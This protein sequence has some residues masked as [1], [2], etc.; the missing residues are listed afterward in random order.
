MTAK[1]LSPTTRRV[2][3]LTVEGFTAKQVAAMT[4]R[5]TGTVAHHLR[6]V[7]AAWGLDR[8]RNLRVQL[9]R[10]ITIDSMTKLLIAQAEAMH[11]TAL[12]NAIQQA[13]QAVAAEH[14]HD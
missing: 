2:V 14:E 5:S 10:R 9:A 7:S 13:T 3:E 1:P 6:L 11:D 12:M 8:S 4:G